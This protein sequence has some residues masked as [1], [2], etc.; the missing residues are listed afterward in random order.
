MRL[1]KKARAKL[2]A[3]ADYQKTKNSAKPDLFGRSF[4]QSAFDAIGAHVGRLRFA[5]QHH[6]L[7]LQVGVEGAFRS[8]VRVA[9]RTAGDGAFATDC[10]FIRHKVLPYI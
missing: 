7:F 1:N 9:V 2:T 6:F 3:R 5:F 4:G 8:E 10:T